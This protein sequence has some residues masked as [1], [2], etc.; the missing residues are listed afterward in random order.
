MASLSYLVRPSS[1]LLN[2]TLFQNKK[3]DSNKAV[4]YQSLWLLGPFILIKI[5]SR[6][7]FFSFIYSCHFTNYS[8]DLEHVEV[9]EMNG[10]VL[11]CCSSQGPMLDSQ[12][13]YQVAHNH[14]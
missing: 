3:I 11:S 7:E 8:N 12:H 4:G 6:L 9:V 14:P 5:Y 13:P 10:P 2:E 1:A